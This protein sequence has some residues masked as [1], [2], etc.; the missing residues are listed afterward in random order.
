VPPTLEGLGVSD[1]H[2]DLI[3]EL[4]PRDPT[5]GGNP[6]PLDGVGARRIFMSALKGR[7]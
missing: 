7:L 1:E 5:A 3:A 6:V 4:A 2:V